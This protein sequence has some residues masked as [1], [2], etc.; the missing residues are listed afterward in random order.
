MKLFL[1]ALIASISTAAA[2][3]SCEYLYGRM[4]SA[5]QMDATSMAQTIQNERFIA[6][7]NGVKVRVFDKTTG[8][9]V[10]AETEGMIESFDLF[11]DKLGLAWSKNIGGVSGVETGVMD[12]TTGRLT[13]FRSRVE[14]GRAINRLHH[15]PLI[16][17][18]H[19]NLAIVAG[20]SP[21]SGELAVLTNNSLHFVSV[22]D[23]RHREL[24][25]PEKAGYTYTLPGTTKYL[26]VGDSAWAVTDSA[27][28]R[29]FTDPMMKQNSAMFSGNNKTHAY[30]TRT[31][32]GS[33][34]PEIVLMDLSSGSIKPIDTSRIGNIHSPVPGEKGIYFIGGNDPAIYFADSANG[35]VTKISGEIQRE[36]DTKLTTTSSGHR[37]AWVDSPDPN[38]PNH[39]ELVTF[40][41]ATGS[42][43]KTKLGEFFTIS[44]L[45]ISPDGN[46]V[47]V[48]GSD[49]AGKRTLI[50]HNATT[51]QHYSTK[52]PAD[53]SSYGFEFTPDGKSIMA[54]DTA[55][56][57]LMAIRDPA[58]TAPKGNDPELLKKIAAGQALKLESD[59]PEIV[60]FF[61]SG[62]FREDPELAHRLLLSLVHDSPLTFDGLM[63]DFPEVISLRKGKPLDLSRLPPATREAWKKSAVEAVDLRMSSM[64]KNEVGEFTQMKDW[65]AMHL[66]TPLLQELPLEER[67][68][69]AA[70]I[71]MAMANS[72]H[73]E[74]PG[75]FQ[76]KFFKFTKQAVR[77][78]FGIEGKK[79]VD[80][81]LVYDRVTKRL[82]PHLLSTEPMPAEAA[83]NTHG[84]YLAKKDPIFVDHGLTD[85]SLITEKTIQWETGGE[86]YTT[87]WKSTVG[88][89]LREVTDSGNSL[90]YQALW[91]DDRLNGMVVVGD[92]MGHDPDLIDEYVDYYKKQGFRFT[93][94]K[95]NDDLKAYME[96]EIS[97]GRLDYL[98]KEAH[99]DGMDR[100]LFRFFQ[101]GDLQVGTKTLTGGKKET[102]TIVHQPESDLKT[103]MISNSE[104]GQWI[105]K[106]E[107]V[108]SSGP[109]VY[110]NTSCS[111]FTKA[112]NEIRSAGSKKLVVFAG[113]GQMDT[114][115]NSEE[116][117][118]R[119]LIH[120][121]REKKTFPE[122]REM[123]AKDPSYNVHGQNGYLLPDDRAFHDLLS[124][125]SGFPINSTIETRNAAGKV[126]HLDGGD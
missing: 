58:K 101:K 43:K 110:F 86:T 56:P 12:P 118:L 25:L 98:V 23:G 67:S 42:L 91:K 95:K 94:P 9:T 48:T 13:K 5:S 93:R 82:V 54:I 100:D 80:V 46:L 27:T 112:C 60:A 121:M 15:N 20:G 124:Q 116:S 107:V 63:R 3:P 111:A 88:R 11:G 117:A 72:A 92:N 79:L 41:R 24:P 97:E 10:E 47:V 34:R 75:I 99:S 1:L 33:T 89:G 39:P 61:K 52:M 55:N 59:I 70:R 29:T 66:L 84:F 96:K 45:K 40:D 64:A 6:N 36:F 31:A 32:P 81:D 104:F 17:S 7:K 37:A 126:M 78:I 2:Q 85:G 109:L 57:K 28:G 102:I 108:D 105:R 16:A 22:R 21:E 119:Q 49:V 4:V 8:K 62:R 90:D 125:H 35:A 51:G 71:S 73:F 114:F 120:G 122:M 106:R 74:I 14:N 26:T 87:R 83:L 38:Y 50:V 77:P 113:N 18:N 30:I 53:F 69:M 123:M 44:Q 103:A 65:E 19:S 76:Q 115:E 68:F